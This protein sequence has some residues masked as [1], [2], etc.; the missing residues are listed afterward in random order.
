[1]LR[2][3]FPPHHE[4]RDQQAEALEILENSNKKFFIFEMPTGSGKSD[5]GYTVCAASGGYIL[6]PFNTLAEQYMRDFEEFGLVD[7]KGKSHY[8]DDPDGPDCLTA[9]AAQNNHDVRCTAYHPRLRQFLGSRM[10][11]TNYANFLSHPKW[12]HRFWLVLDE[13]HNIE[14][15]ILNFAGNVLTP[16]ECESKYGLTLPIFKRPDETRAWLQA[17]YLRALAKRLDEIKSQ[18]QEYKDAGDIPASAEDRVKK[19]AKEQ[20]AISRRQTA[21]NVMLQGGLEGLVSGFRLEVG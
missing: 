15:Q 6:T 12:P 5:I 20:D 10:S 3:H 16:R 19:L 17:E 1:M 4:P 7:L 9:S 21:L 2:D 18:L 13:G 14:S 8:Y 11:I